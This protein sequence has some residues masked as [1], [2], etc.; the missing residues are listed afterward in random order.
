[1]TEIFISFL[2]TLGSS[3]AFLPALSPIL[4]KISDL[5]PSLSGFLIV[6]PNRLGS[7]QCQEL[8]GSCVCFLTLLLTPDF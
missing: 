8:L 7:G 3:L 1:M 2:L 6:V 4:V 5:F